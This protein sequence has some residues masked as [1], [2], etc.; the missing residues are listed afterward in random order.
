V[1]L[2]VA[3]LG[4]AEHVLLLNNDI[5]GAKPGWLG[6][7]LAQS[8]RPEIGAVGARLLFSD[9]TPQH[10]GIR[11]GGQGGAADNLDLSLYFGLGLTCRTVSAVTAACLMVKRS[12]WN[13]VNG[14]DES[15]RVAFNDVDFCL[16]VMRAGYRNVYTPLAE[17]THLESASRGRRHPAEDE[18]QFGVRWGPFPQGYDRYIGGHIY[19]FQPLDYR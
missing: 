10:E 13:E 18:R 14:F 17:L 11:V 7:L 8:Q 3:A 4:P 12:V 15:L 5:V 1:N 19:S 6:A 16:R 9:G 2:G